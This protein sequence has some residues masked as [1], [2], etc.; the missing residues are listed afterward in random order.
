VS[1]LRGNFARLLA[2]LALMTGL[3]GSAMPG[4]AATMPARPAAAHMAMDC[5]HGS[6]HKAPTQRLPGAGDCCM[7]SVCAMS[8]ALP[9]VPSGVAQPAFSALPGY[10]LAVQRRPADIVAAPIPHPPKSIA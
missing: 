8:L 9:A 10:P 2:L 3:I 5:D 1:D 6:H 4:L 7:V